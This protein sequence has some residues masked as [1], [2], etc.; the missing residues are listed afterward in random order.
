MNLDRLSGFSVDESRGKVYLVVGQDVYEGAFPSVVAPQTQGT[1]SDSNVVVPSF[2]DHLAP[3]AEGEAVNKDAAP[4][5]DVSNEPAA[6]PT[7]EP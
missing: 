5:G 2:E 4:T 3:A 7:V 6:R 1:G